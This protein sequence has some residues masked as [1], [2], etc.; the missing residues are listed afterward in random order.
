MNC[1]ILAIDWMAGEPVITAIGDQG[2]V[3]LSHQGPL[4]W[5]VGAEV[6][7]VG[8]FD[9]DGH[10]PCPTNAP[11]QQCA[12]CAPAWMDCVFEP[13]EHDAPCVLCDR[14]HAVYVAFYGTLPKVGMTSAR[15]LSTRLAEQGADAYFVAQRRPDRAAARATERTIAFLHGLP[16]R[17]RHRE[18]LGGWGRPLDRQRIE[19]KAEMWRET[20]AQR[21]DVESLQWTDQTLPAL[22][23]PPHVIAPVGRHQG[24]WLGAK[25]RF[26]CYQTEAPFGKAVHALDRHG[27]IG[28]WVTVQ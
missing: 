13:R 11:V 6:H 20:L 15:R 21:F 23:S 5:T 24:T 7:C 14:E 10:I 22:P 26:L 19:A 16:E 18:Y 4:D 28:R 27:L 9:R 2:L 8:R 25:G 1:H 3:N 12:D 17:R